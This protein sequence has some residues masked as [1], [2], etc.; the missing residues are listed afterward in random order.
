VKRIV[1]LLLGTID[2][3]VSPL[4]NRGAGGL[5][6]EGVQV[7]E[8][9]LVDEV[10]EVVAGL[11]AVVVDLAVAVFGGGPGFSAVGLVKDEGVAVPV[12]CGFVGF[13]LFE[14][15]Q[16]LQEEEPGGLPG[17]VEFGGAARRTSS[18]FLKACSNIERAL[19]AD[20]ETGGFVWNTTALS[21]INK[22]FNFSRV[23]L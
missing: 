6:P 19:R 7:G 15:V 11:G 23:A 4:M 22:D 16:V 14:V 1:R 21:A 18:M 2:V 12:E 3:F 10:A 8:E 17:V 9:L 13:V 20:R 5:L